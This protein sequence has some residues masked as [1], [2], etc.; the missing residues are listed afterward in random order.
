MK[1]PVC[2]DATYFIQGPKSKG[3]ACT[4][5]NCRWVTAKCAKEI[6]KALIKHFQT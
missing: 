5:R 6:A 3:R 4:N 1:C 2:G